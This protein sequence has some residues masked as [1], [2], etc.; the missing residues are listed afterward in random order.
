MQLLK[1]YTHV[2]FR[3][4]EDLP[5]DEGII[6]GHTYMNACGIPYPV[7]LITL[8]AGFYAPNGSFVSTLV[9]SCDCVE[10]AP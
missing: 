2:K 9:V 1:L 4:N 7:Y 10:Q 5:Y 3:A 6:V 8:L